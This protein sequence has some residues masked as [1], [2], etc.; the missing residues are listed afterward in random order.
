ML[1]PLLPKD[2]TE[3]DAAFKTVEELHEVID[4][5]LDEGEIKN[6]ALTG[7]FGSGKSSVLQTLRKRY[8]EFEYLPISLATLQ[9]NEDSDN[10]AGLNI[11]DEQIELLNRKI[12]YSI[13]QQL[14]YR[15]KASTVPN[16]RFRRIIHID[17]KRLKVLSFHGVLFFVAILIAFEPSWF[18]VSSIYQ[19]L[20]FGIWNIVP[21][22]L[23]VGYMLYFLFIVLGYVIKSYS[24]SKL[25][26]LNLKDGEI[27]LK[28]E[29][30]IFNKHLDEILYFFQVTK[31]NVVIIEDL[32]R[33]GTSK[34]FLK[35]RE[36]NQLINESKIVGRNL[37]FLYAVKDDIFINEE[38]TKFFDYITT[39]I[40]VI[41]PSN[42]KDKL[43]VALKERGLDENEIM[44]GDLADMAFFIQDMRILTNIANEF[45]Q[46]IEKLCTGNNQKLN[47]TKLLAMI[48]YKNYYPKDFAM[49]HR[50]EGKVYSCIKAKPLFAKF[51][52][53][54]IELKEKALEEEY[55]EY[56]K[57]RHLKEEDLRLL[58]LLKLKS[59]CTNDLRMFIIDGHEYSLELIADNEKLFDTLLSSSSINYTFTNYHYNNHRTSI[60]VNLEDIN[61][62]MNFKTRMALLKK[63]E[64]DFERKRSELIREKLNVHKYKLSRLI[65]Y[66]KQGNSEPY[67]SIK[68]SEMMDVFIR[69]GFIDEE[70][71]DYISFFYEG[72]VSLSDRELLLSIKRDIPKEY[73]Y[74]ID[75]VENFVKELLPYMFETKAI[76][77]NDLLDYVSSFHK[78]YFNLMMYILETNQA[79]LDFLAQY[80]LYGNAQKQVYEHYIKWD[81]VQ[82]WINIESWSNND[83][84][85]ILIEGW[86][87][88]S[89]K[90]C[91][92]ARTWLNCHYEFLTDRF[93]NIGKERSLDLVIDS[94]FKELNDKNPELLKRSI[95][96]LAYEINSYNLC[97]M[98]NYLCNDLQ[99]K[100]GNLNLSRIR[101]TKYSIF[102]EHIENN[103]D[104]AIMHFSKDCKDETKDSLLFILNS[105]KIKTDDKENYLIGQKE[106]LDDDSNID[107]DELKTLAYNL[108]L[109]NPT[110]R[111][112]VA[113]Y[114][115]G[116]KD[117]HILIKYIGHFSDKLGK[118]MVAEEGNE[119]LS[120][121]NY[122]LGTNKL[123][124]NAYSSIIKSFWGEFNGYDGLRAL[125]QDRLLLLLSHNMLPF[126][127]GNTNVLKETGIYADY[128]IK[129]HNQLLE[130]LSVSYISNSDVVYKLLSSNVF[131][132]EE[133]KRII[134][135]TPKDLLVR[136]DKVAN[137]VLNVIL[138]TDLKDIDEETII[139][140]VGSAS[141]ESSKV[142]I[143]LLLINE[144]N[145]DNSKIIELLRLLGDKYADIADKSKRPALEKTRWNIKLAEALRY[146][147]FVFSVK[148]YKNSSKENSD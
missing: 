64:E 100:E 54:E 73:S 107:T 120:L 46:Y 104:K 71:Y 129:Y 124:I 135:I 65:G 67:K 9:A 48:V 83:E 57:V 50:R 62:T 58:Y 94:E 88:Y 38:R 8:K 16:S 31:Y 22:I 10:K 143:I 97:L 134:T 49:L 82:S 40:P 72:M 59:R 87:K 95:D 133:K 14:I 105:E 47:L 86:L 121:R 41:N 93:E 116:N 7:P 78:D 126:S 51:A 23:A 123:A 102:I 42:S 137:I 17:D 85:N 6:I 106:L 115:N 144:Y 39:V 75:K 139:K 76:L 35:L 60:N 148:W 140:I 18:I 61:Q 56:L 130:N 4:K 110:W 84:K 24:N 68:L 132:Y 145:Y 43:K 146:K 77:N 112:V 128:L 27:E 29:N 21:D 11:D 136:S 70:Y 99:V 66:Y 28:E 20:D 5:A 103:I 30:S 34:I 122:L 25:N 118:Q 33:F 37:V 19:L 113:Y 127:E 131:T 79:P 138:Y 15:E 91:K 13:L 109:I 96:S 44:D 45:Q 55:Q 1:E 142:Y 32:D 81:E 90:I 111:N 119:Y 125:D 117:E 2:L 69:R 92:E 53:N 101:D 98:A 89:K 26:K 74:H 52:L 80:Y 141:D 114:N 12:E 147:G 36:L 63:S 3:K 108:F